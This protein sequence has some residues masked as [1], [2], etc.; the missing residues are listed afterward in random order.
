MLVGDLGD[1]FAG[2]FNGLF[3]EEL[4]RLYD[5]TKDKRYLELASRIAYHW[6]SSKFFRVHVLFGFEIG[7]LAK[8]VYK[9]IFDFLSPRPLNT[10]T[11]M[12]VKSNTDLVYGLLKLYDTTKNAKISEAISKWTTSIRKVTNE[13]RM[14]YSYYNAK[15]G[16]GS[17]VSLESNHAI[18]DALLEIWLRLKNKQILETVKFVAN[19]WIEH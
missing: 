4:V 17:V 3:I 18:L 19:A 7:G 12:M 1:C 14:F 10:Y 9:T 15:K 8:L 6:I 13:R 11:A 5:M 2:S 16:K